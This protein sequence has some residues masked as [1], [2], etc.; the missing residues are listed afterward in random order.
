[1]VLADSH[2][3]QALPEVQGTLPWG[4]YPTATSQRIL[5]KNGLG[6]IS[7]PIQPR[8]CSTIQDMSAN[9][10]ERSNFAHQFLR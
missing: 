5:S 8:K 9:L 2:H 3:A 6:A 1:M 4:T 10:R 7:A